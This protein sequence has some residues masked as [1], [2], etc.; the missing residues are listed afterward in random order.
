MAIRRTTKSATDKRA[1][2]R[3]VANGDSSAELARIKQSMNEAGSFDEQ[4]RFAKEYIELFERN[5]PKRKRGEKSVWD[6]IVE[7]GK[8]IPPEE[9]AKHPPDGATNL[10]HYLHGH[11]KQDPDA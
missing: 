8:E 9:L 7:V 5:P 4:I 11:P 3:V 6:W 1:A 2:K 10:H